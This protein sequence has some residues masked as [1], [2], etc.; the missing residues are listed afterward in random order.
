MQSVGSRPGRRQQVEGPRHLQRV[1][2][3]RHLGS[4]HYGGNA[5][6]THCP[7]VH[8]G[9]RWSEELLRKVREERRRLVDEGTLVRPC[10]YIALALGQLSLGVPWNGE[11][12]KVSL[13]V[14]HFPDVSAP[15]LTH[16]KAPAEGDYTIKPHSSKPSTMAQFVQQST[17]LAFFVGQCLGRV[18]EESIVRAAHRLRDFPQSN[19][20]V[21]TVELCTRIFHALL[22][23]WV[24][25]WR[26]ITRHV[27][28]L[29]G[30]DEPTVCE[31][32]RVP[33]PRRS[34]PPQLPI[35]QYLRP[36]RSGR[37][38][39][40]G[41]HTAGLHS[42]AAG[43]MGISPEAGGQ[44]VHDTVQAHQGWGEPVPLCCGFSSPGSGGGTAY[45]ALSRYGSS[46]LLGIQQLQWMPR[47]RQVPTCPSSI[48]RGQEGRSLQS[49][50]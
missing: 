22:S 10:P 47:R 29:T 3:R 13:R 4:G 37:P 2:S 42:A 39:L 28:Q 25:A 9:K 23:W 35:A 27:V 21:W 8:G 30:R 26:R 11:V 15:E 12:P 16:W 1:H 14:E 33:N 18:H 46:D 40:A 7:H 24:T 49:A 41:S 38:V 32:V 36:R 43:T 31:F 6:V 17:H 5:K 20:S 34:R 45:P 48:P 44:R 19:P 50:M